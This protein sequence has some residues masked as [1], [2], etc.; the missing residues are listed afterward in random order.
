MYTMVCTCILFLTILRA[1][2]S[3]NARCYKEVELGTH[4]KYNIDGKKVK[5]RVMS[6]FNTGLTL[7]KRA[8]NSCVY[9]RIPYSFKL[10]DI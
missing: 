5:K 6:L 8:F 10:Y 2:Y 9:I 7:F 1:D 4:K 3:K